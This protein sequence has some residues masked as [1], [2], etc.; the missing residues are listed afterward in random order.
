MDH[1]LL[2]IHKTVF[3]N[4]TILFESV[5]SGLVRVWIIDP[6][7]CFV[8]VIKINIFEGMFTWLMVIF[9]VG[10]GVIAIN[11]NT[12]ALCSHS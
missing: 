11:C 8:L 6:F 10:C 4:G 3:T 7:L 12:F 1:T 9:V 5:S 2:Q